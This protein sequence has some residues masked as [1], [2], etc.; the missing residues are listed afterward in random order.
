[1][2]SPARRREAVVHIQQT[3][4]TSERR[5]CRTLHQPRSTQR[6]CLRRPDNDRGLLRAIRRIVSHEPRAGY[7]TVTR[8][9]KR[10]GWLVNTKR[11][12]RLWKQ[13]GLKVSG[14]IRKRRRLGSSVN[15]TQRL[16]AERLNQVWSYDFVHDQTETGRRLKWM[17]IIDEYSRECLALEVGYSMSAR[18]VVA[19]L[20]RLVAQRGAPAYIRSDNGP[21][22]VAKAVKK[23]LQEAGI[24]A[25]YIEPGAPW[26]N[27]YSE[28]FNS[29]FR[30]EFLNLELFSNQLE[31][32]VLG[33]EYQQKYNHLRPHS[34]LGNLTPAEFAA[35]CHA[36]LRPFDYVEAAC[37]P[38]GSL[39]H[40]K[41][42]PILS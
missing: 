28:S 4:S 10:Q 32:K 11:V 35:R 2:V 24:G 42:Q 12:H 16:R 38:Q 7:R 19:T 3:L 40:P 26:Q 15:S 27:A 33:K 22:F 20:Q 41:R 23:W 14:K 34:A 30:D 13:E 36:T 1:M 29:R 8:Y 21:E 37:A 9:L 17:P 5:A 25:L 39:S 31:A 18:E 6:Y